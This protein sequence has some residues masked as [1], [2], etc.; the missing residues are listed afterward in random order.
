MLA[1]FQPSSSTYRPG[2]ADLLIDRGIPKRYIGCDPLRHVA[3]HPL[4]CGETA[5]FLR[6]PW[7][8]GSGFWARTGW[9]D[10]FA[11][12]GRVSDPQSPDDLPLRVD[13]DGR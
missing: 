8:A 7:A 2:Y 13:M 3:K 9:L 11:T 1:L 4:R 12:K 5:E 6:P 10:S